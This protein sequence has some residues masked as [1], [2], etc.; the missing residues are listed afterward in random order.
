MPRHSKKPAGVKSPFPKVIKPMLATLTSEPFDKEDWIY[1]LKWDGYRVVAMVE[2]SKVVLRSREAQDFTSRYRVLVDALSA[3]KHELVLDGEVVVLD[4]N[5]QPDFN[6]LQ[7]YNGSQ[8]LV[9]Y[10]FDLLWLDGYSLLELPLTVRKASLR[11]LIDDNGLIKYSEHF[12]SGIELFEHVQSMG[13]EGVI[14]KKK[15]SSYMPGKRSNSWL[16]VKANK[17]QEF[18]IGGYT[19]SEN[20]QPFKSILFGY[21]ENGRLVYVHHGGGGFTF[22]QKQDFLKELQK[23]EIQKSPFV[24]EV[25]VDAPVHWVK[26]VFVAE[27]E[28]STKET[29]NGFIRHP[30]IFK[31][32][33][34][35]KKPADVVKELN[36]RETSAEKEAP[37]AAPSKKA[38]KRAPIA[39]SAASNWPEILSQ[40]ITS[41]ETFDIEGHSLTLTNVEKKLWNDITKAELIQYYH[42]VSPYILPHLKDRP[43]SLHIK[44]IAPGAPGL[45]VKDMEGRQP[46]WATIFTTE[47]KHK[48]KGKRNQIDYLVCQ[49][50]A[51]LFYLV[52]LGCIDINPWTSRMASPLQPDY[53]VIDLD[54]SD[55]DFS[56]VI[57][58]AKAAKEVFDK[59][60]LT[61]FIKTSGK[62]GMHLCLPAEGFGFPEARKMAESI[63]KEIYYLLPGITTT[64]VSINQRGNKLYLDPNQNDEADTIASAYSARPFHLPTV[65]TP[66]EW[67]EV[68]SK[69][70]PQAFTIA[71][72]P[73]RLKKKGD[74]F[75]GV[76]DKKHAVKNRKGLMGFL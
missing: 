17:R 30:A 52:N 71:S 23:I 8:P 40:K 64:N 75:Y 33:R 67:K 14:A 16:K 50:K 32:L 38:V 24:N 69:L 25:A 26:P 58:S 36:F 55:D 56:K 19:R 29:R 5:G 31:G 73:A 4:D 59:H 35:D 72:I 37:P 74:L 47:R 44:H 28:I 6:E 20:N 11:K 65:S 63:C 45:Y 51:T 57:E 61:A 2:K 22:R 15:E 70:D 62:T 43:L 3:F 42:I 49:N 34:T 39:L 21:Y 9:Y 41:K 54:P 1:E 53:I 12:E 7:R 60:K 48:K 76:L 18:V 68:N 13:L 46:E 10:V 66:L 27:F